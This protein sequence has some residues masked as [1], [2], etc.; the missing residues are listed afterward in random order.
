MVRPT[1]SMQCQIQLWVWFF[2]H[3]LRTQWTCNYSKEIFIIREMWRET[4]TM[5]YQMKNNKKRQYY[6]A[7]PG[8]YV[9][10]LLFSPWKIFD[11]LVSFIQLKHCKC[12][13]LVLIL[14]CSVSDEYTDYYGKLILVVCTGGIL[15]GFFFLML[16]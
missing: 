9:I 6:K 1:I 11:K 3:D 4:I 8:C 14:K 15:N 12:R 13:I 7:Y 10:K 5:V 2:S 16:S